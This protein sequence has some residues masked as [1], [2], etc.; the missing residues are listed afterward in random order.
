MSIYFVGDIQ[1][2]Y[3]ELDALLT[4]INF[5]STHDLL[6]I[7]GDLVARGPDSLATLRLIK[8][9]GQSAKVVLGN[10]DLHLLAIH[11]GIRHAKP[12]DALTKLLSAPDRE[13]LLNWLGR[14]P[15]IQKL[16]GEETYMTHAGIP[17]H[18]SPAK[19]MK[20]AKKAHKKIA[21]AQQHEWLSIMYG[22]KP[23]HWD[24]ADDKITKFRYTINA[25]TRMRF[26]HADGSLDFDCKNNLKNAPPELTPW[27]E[28]DH[29]PSNTHWLFGHWAA[30]MGECRPSNVFA[31]DTGCAWGHHL[32]ML[33]WHDKQIFTESAHK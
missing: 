9:L 7:A 1:G 27:F 24:D 19:A 29:I 23:N 22:E 12:Q 33:R 26:C 18:W 15:L 6:Y 13:E 14:Q 8:S 31:L 16:P 10:H 17:P 20:F 5:S 4:K 11:A 25:L 2:C 32:T 21:S 3:S 30:L 28:F